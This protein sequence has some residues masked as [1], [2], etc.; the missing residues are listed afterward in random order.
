MSG[1]SDA[2][3]NWQGFGNV[4]VMDVGAA[5]R[6]ARQTAGLSRE[7]VSQRTK[8]QLAKIEA[9]EAN[10]FERLP[11]G[12]Y[13]DGLIR[14]YA[15]EVGLD[16]GELVTRLHRHNAIPL[17]DE[18]ER[19]IPAERQDADYADYITPP[20]PAAAAPPVNVQHAAVAPSYEPAEVTYM[21][22]S[23][24]AHSTPA[25][26]GRRGGVGK[27]VLPLLALLASIGLGAYLYDR[28]R[29]FASREEIATPAISHENETAAASATDADAAN[30]SRRVEPVPTDA[31][32]ADRPASTEHHAAKPSEGPTA[33]PPPPVAPRVTDS[34]R[35][36][37]APGATAAP[38]AEVP[39][40]TEGPTPTEPRRTTGETAKT[41]AAGATEP[42]PAEPRDEGIV[43][44][45]SGSWTL[46]TR[47]E[48]SSVADFQ[49]LQLGYRLQL[50]QSG[51]RVSGEGVKAIEN[52][53]PIAE[54]GQT[55]IAVQGTLEGGRLTLTFTERG[56]R[57]ESVGKMILDVQE[58][59]VLRGRFSSSAARSS[60]TAEARRP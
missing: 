34:P 46:D 60:G 55:P 12:I 6:E 2:H 44:D 13:L 40:A 1:C 35:A 5:L 4:P 53:R 25:Q 38:P 54:A 17:E 33:V 10:A 47:V 48:T 51:D 57:R 24:G 43:T 59:G 42:A 11:E 28:T 50:Q 49:G 26:P 18:I 21:A 16:G 58:D 7:D 23:F 41:T 45:V 8:I 56:T 39:R 37:D 14:A 3:S 32:P 30:A 15:A 27:Y 31:I 19:D 9:L 52:G 22:P 20:P 36:G 29:P